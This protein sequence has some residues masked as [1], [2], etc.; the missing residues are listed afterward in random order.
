M[1]LDEVN[2]GRSPPSLDSTSDNRTMSALRYLVGLGR[3]R[4]VWR[5]AVLG[6]RGKVFPKRGGRG[7]PRTRVNWIRARAN[8]VY[9][10]G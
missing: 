7:Q 5:E 9:T 6:V 2:E 3:R 10:D 8:H 4:C 1:G